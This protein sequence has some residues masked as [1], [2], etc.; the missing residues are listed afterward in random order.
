MSDGDDRNTKAVWGR[1]LLAALFALVVFLPIVEGNFLRWDD[2]A[3]YVGNTEYQGVMPESLRWMGTSFLLGHWQPLTWLSCSVDHAIWGMNS[4]GW[5]VTN[6]LLHVINTVLVYFICLT[7]FR[8]FRAQSDSQAVL[9][10][11]LFYAVHPLRVEV[12]AW[13]A[14]RGYLL[15]TAFCLLAVLFYLRETD[16]GRYPVKALFCFVLAALCKG[17]GMMLPPVFLLAD[18][19][20]FKRI[21]SIRTAVSCVLQKVPF[22][23]V[24]AFVGVMAFLAKKL[25]GGM[26]SVDNYGLALRIG[27]AVQGAWFY[28]LKMVAPFNLSPLYYEKPQPGTVAVGFILTAVASSLLFLFRKRLRMLI[29]TLA[30]FVVLIFPMLGITQSGQQTAADRFMYLSA[31]PFS[32]LLAAGLSRLRKPFARPVCLGLTAILI[33]FGVLSTT[34]SGCWTNDLAM[35]TRAI[36][37]DDANA[38]AHNSVGAAFFDKGLYAEANAEF[39][40]ALELKPWSAL[41]RHN[42]AL[43]L[44]LHGQFDAAFR[45]WRIAEVFAK[46]DLPDLLSRI[47]LYRGWAYEQVDQYDSAEAEYTQVAENMEFDCVTRARGFYARANMYAQQGRRAEAVEDFEKVLSL[48]RSTHPL[49]TEARI[50]FIGLK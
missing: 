19:I 25:D 11:T 16:R 42:K 49:Y 34:W 31:F 29:C 4:E 10:A 27:Q 22:F 45:Q 35:W 44:A 3:L 38:H 2:Q 12:V 1:A 43:I 6:L 41:A 7:V 14:T 21:H 26:A 33:L 48:V 37:I 15:C 20:V 46:T 30:A 39:D 17:I 8:C 36:Q 5:H 40:R 18:W 9:L 32:I 23:I 13:L 28:L 47:Y 50:K 24:S